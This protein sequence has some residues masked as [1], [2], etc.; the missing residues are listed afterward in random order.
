MKLL[1]IKVIRILFGDFQDVMNPTLR[2]LFLGNFLSSLG[3]GMTL[4]L[5]LVYLKDIRG[6][7]TSF[8]GFLL[9]FMALIS[10]VFGGPV[11]WLIDRIGPKKVIIAGLLLEGSAVALWSIVTTRNE[12]IVVAA[13]SSLGTLMIWPPQTVLVTRM[14]EEK[15]RQRVFG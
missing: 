1:A 2:R 15:D 14:S 13:M 6:F 5:L 7:T 12:A 8:G 9:S 4:S 3:T 10:I 11:G